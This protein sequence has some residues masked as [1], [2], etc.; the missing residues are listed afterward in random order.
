M[1]VEF[2]FIEVDFGKESNQC[3]GRAVVVVSNYLICFLFHC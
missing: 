1:K 3:L 2:G